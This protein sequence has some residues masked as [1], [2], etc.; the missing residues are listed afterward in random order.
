MRPWALVAVAIVVVAG[1]LI[2]WRVLAA[3]PPG[4]LAPCTAPAGLTRHPDAPA[5]NAPGGGGLLVVDSGF[6]QSRG[7]HGLTVSIGAM[8]ANTSSMIAY[9]TRIRFHVLDASRASAVA[10]TSGEALYQ[11][12]PVIMPGQ[13]IGAAA[14]TDLIS[15]PI[16]GVATVVAAVQAELD[17]TQWWIPSDAWQALGTVP[18]HHV[19]TERSRVDSE[20]GLIRFTARSP[21]CRPVSD[22]GVATV[23]RNR[24]G[25]IVGGNFFW[26]MNDQCDPGQYTAVVSAISPIPPGVDDALTQDYPYCD[27]VPPSPAQLQPGDPVNAG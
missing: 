5:A 18:A 19:A 6:T 27:P 25:A 21:Y 16:T 23:F 26:T 15:N 7:G 4:S 12:I 9:R 8:V 10:A 11:V 24:S 17:T 22:R 2:G 1:G 20:T 3:S 13:R 14:F